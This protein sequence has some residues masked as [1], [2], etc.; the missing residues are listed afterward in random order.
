LKESDDPQTDY[1]R[2]LKA[3]EALAKEQWKGDSY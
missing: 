3:L 1:K 2:E